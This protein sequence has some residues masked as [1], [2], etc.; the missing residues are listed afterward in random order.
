[1][2]SPSSTL[3]ITT[4]TAVYKPLIG[5][6]I[7]MLVAMG[8]G[9]FAY[10]PMLPI[11]EHDVQLSVSSAGLLA[12]FNYVGYLLGALV[13]AWMPLRSMERRFRLI[14]VCLIFSSLTTTAMAWSESFWLWAIFRGISG[15]CSAFVMVYSSSSIMDWLYHHRQSSKVGI[16]YAGV[17]LGIAMTGLLVPL[18]TQI[19]NWQTGWY[20]LGIVSF[21]LAI[22][23][24]FLLTGIRQFIPDY[25]HTKDP[26]PTIQP[27]FRL[28]GI[29]A[30]YGLEGLGYIVMSTFVTVFFSQISSFSWLGSVSWI[31]LGLAAAPSTW[32]WSYAAQR[33]GIRKATY[34][35]FLIQASSILIPTLVPGVITAVIG[36]VL[37]GGTFLGITSLALMIGRQIDPSR[38]S[39]IIGN[40]TAVY[41]VGQIIGPVGAGAITSALH[42]YS[43]SMLLSGML[44]LIAIA[45]LRVSQTKTEMSYEKE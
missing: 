9:R 23:S 2:V 16:F 10:T 45:L 12:S 44:L 22:W 19:G 17:G 4:G 29:T 32:L 33:W 30:A 34:A 11:M 43:A 40:L 21:I 3:S 38:S 1:M 35:A 18:F 6:S 20:G 14:A 25:V 36:S 42:T 28:W 13:A 15:I 39:T 5:G 37:F 27:S 41:G 31:I 26:A 7:A 24:L 8:I